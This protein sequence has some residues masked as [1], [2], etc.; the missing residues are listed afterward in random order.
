MKIFISAVLVILSFTANAKTELRAFNV[1]TVFG[2]YQANAKAHTTIYVGEAKDVSG[3]KFINRLEAHVN[4]VANIMGPKGLLSYTVYAT[5]NYEVALMQ[6]PNE[7]IMNQAFADVGM[8][9]QQDADQFLETKVWESTHNLPTALTAKY[10]EDIL[11]KLSLISS[12]KCQG[13]DA[14]YPYA[15]ITYNSSNDRYTVIEEYNLDVPGGSQGTLSWIADGVV[16]QNEIN[17]TGA[18]GRRVIGKRDGSE[19]KVIIQYGNLVAD[20]ICVIDGF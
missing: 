18:A 20:F 15:E 19:Y 9:V 8:A 1:E 10:F 11:S 6:W 4:L 7:A 12:I 2:R 16:S 14:D 13:I 3:N 17:L 5:E